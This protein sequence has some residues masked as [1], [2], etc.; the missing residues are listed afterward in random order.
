MLIQVNQEDIDKGIRKS[1]CRCPIAQAFHR[2]GYKEITVL[3]LSDAVSIRYYKKS[4]QCYLGPKW[5]SEM[6][7]AW[8]KGGELSPFEFE[9][10]E[11]LGKGTLLR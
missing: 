8:D 4:E 9:A 11:W 5:V 1:A 2:L 10:V 3:P 6:V 7:D